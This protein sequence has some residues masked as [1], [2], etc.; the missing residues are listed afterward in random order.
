MENNEL[1][2]NLFK[3]DTISRTCIRDG[4][5]DEVCKP[6]QIQIDFESRSKLIEWLN[7]LVE[8]YKLQPETLY[9]AVN[10]IDLYILK[11]V[12]PIGSYQLLAAT[13]LYTATKYNETNYPAL[14]EFI[15]LCDG[16][17]S[18]SNFIEMEHNILK[19][20]HYSLSLISYTTVAYAMIAKDNPPEDFVDYLINFSRKTLLTK[21]ITL[22][23]PTEVAKSILDLMENGFNVDPND[24]LKKIKMYIVNAIK[25]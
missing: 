11:N 3:Q 10:M 25:N 12:V 4:G 17:Y 13:S 1:Y 8:I 22:M 23:K 14:S 7:E 2:Y 19:F 6:Y 18:R 16:L 24:L 20:C 21:G 9:I 15:Y 5:R